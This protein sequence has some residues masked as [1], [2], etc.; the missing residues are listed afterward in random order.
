MKKAIFNRFIIILVLALLISSIIFSITT[1][2]ILRKKIREDMISNLRIIDYAL[3][4]SGNINEQLKNIKE[5]LK[6]YNNQAIRYTIINLEGIVVADSSVSDINFMEDHSYREEYKEA[7]AS[8]EG[9]ARRMSDTL[10]VSMVYVAIKSLD[11]EYILRSSMPLS[12]TG[13]FIDM[14]WPALLLAVGISLIFSIII[15][16]GLS[17]SI[18]MPLQEITEELLK[19]K[20]KDPEFHFN[21]YR[22]EE[23]NVIADTVMKMSQAVKSSMNQIEFEKMI[24]Q[25]FFSNASHELKTPLTSIRGYIELLENGIANNKE[26]EKDF[27]QRIKKETQN[28]TNLIN[29]ILM[30]SRLETNEVEVE[31]SDVRICPLIEDVISSLKPMADENSIAIRVSC[32]PLII[33]ANNQQIRELFT[34]L[35]TNAIK[36]N[37]PGG[38]VYVTV[39]LELDKI[40]I[41]VQDTGVGIPEDAIQRVFERFYRVDK[42]RSKKIGG[43]GLGLSIV[44]HIVNYYNGTIKLESELGLGSK[45]TVHLPNL[46]NPKNKKSNYKKKGISSYKS[47]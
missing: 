22:Y 37:K 28:M 10:K 35:I 15:S 19:L 12:I 45:F 26:M 31:L 43:T 30:I 33:W 9:Y 6:Q 20:D 3:D 34:N 25:E 23:M 13:E 4:Y 11:S 1:S 38:E 46:Q 47:K 40:K 2:T 17:R 29:D 16:H 8:G 44:K 18:I 21:E 32:K 27:M 14:L 24:R 42:G 5:I 36:Y 39:N 41:I 7:L